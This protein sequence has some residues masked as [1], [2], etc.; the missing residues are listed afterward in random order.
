MQSTPLDDLHRSRF[1]AFRRL[2]DELDQAGPPHLR[3][4]AEWIA[5]SGVLD[6]QPKPARLRQRLG[7]GSLPGQ[8]RDLAYGLAAQARLGGRSARAGECAVLIPMPFERAD[9]VGLVAPVIQRLSAQGK[10]VVLVSTPTVAFAWT[11]HVEGGV[12]L[13]E[14]LL[15]RV[16]DR[17][18]ARALA[19]ADRTAVQAWLGRAGFPMSRTVQVMSVLDA[20]WLDRLTM[21]RLLHGRAWESVFG[22]HFVNRPGYLAAIRDAHRSDTTRR[23]VLLQHGQFTRRSGFHDF[24]GADVL[25]T[26]AERW[27]GELM[28]YPQVS[29]YALPAAEVTGNPRYEA[30]AKARADDDEGT[31]GRTESTVLYIRE[32]DA[33]TAIDVMVAKATRDLPNARVLV[34]PHPSDK[35]GELTVKLYRHGFPRASIAAPRAE[36]ADLIRSSDVVIGS[37]S[38]ALL[39]A[40]AHGKPVLEIREPR[41][42]P[43]GGHAFPFRAT[44][45]ASELRDLIRWLIADRSVRSAEI[46]RQRHAFRDA[47]GPTDG[48]AERVARLITAQR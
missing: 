19:R 18:R 42:G 30:L 2:C 6:P 5:R 13:I 44:D 17:A 28:H 4:V 32:A 16:S 11:R 1:L 45:S 29:G 15:H 46:E 21:G 8:L 35:K 43:R 48:A 7:L 23:V 36:T 26:W 47:L 27:R 9:Y 41:Q 39:D 38:T 12:V 33:P 34:K 20:Y 37:G 24:T 3:D 22:I 14:P 40:V 31:R 10:T 25:A